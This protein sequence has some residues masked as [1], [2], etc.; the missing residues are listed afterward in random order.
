M[1]AHAGHVLLHRLA[2]DLAAPPPGAKPEVRAAR[3]QGR[4]HLRVSRR[5]AE[6]ATATP[7][8]E[9]AATRGWARWC[10]AGTEAGRWSRGQADP[11]LVQARDKRRAKGE[12]V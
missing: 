8:R 11:V 1:L 10:S 6:E 5:L 12:K 3:L 7:V 2:R 9:A 4:L